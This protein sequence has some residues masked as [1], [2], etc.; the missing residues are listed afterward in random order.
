[1]TT[2]LKDGLFLGDL[3]SAADYEFLCANKVT[4]VVN[5]CGREAGNPWEGAAGGAGAGRI[6]YLTYAWPASGDVPILDESNRVLDD[7]YAF[8]EEASEAGEAAL[9]HCTDGHSRAAFAAAV[10]LML[11]YRWCVHAAHHF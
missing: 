2:K 9:I 6:E 1:M 5:C 10:Y 4:H 11:K 8:I 7:L 3:D